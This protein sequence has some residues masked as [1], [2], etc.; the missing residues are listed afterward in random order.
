MD[1]KK[2]GELIRTMR[3]EKNMT[4]QELADVLH[5]S[6]P[7][8]SKYENGKGFPDISLLE[9]LATALDITVSELLS[10]KREEIPEKQEEAVRDAIRQ[11]TIQKEIGRKKTCERVLAGICILLTVFLYAVVFYRPVKLTSVFVRDTQV[12]YKLASNRIAFTSYVNDNG[13][14]KCYTIHGFQNLPKE[15]LNYVI[16][17]TQEKHG[18]MFETSTYADKFVPLINMEDPVGGPVV[19]MNWKEEAT[20]NNQEQ[21][22]GIDRDHSLSN[23]LESYLESK[24]FHIIVTARKYGWDEHNPDY[25]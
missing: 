9:P 20:L 3:H 17:W 22:I 25:E 10:G 4:Q 7:A 19:L 8:V 12:T 1:A 16:L 24:D 5:V 14:I 21:I 13:E 18:I 11:S 6:A 23:P 2:T 15:S